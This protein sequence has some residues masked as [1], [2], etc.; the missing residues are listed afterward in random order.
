MGS[1]QGLLVACS[2]P[3]ASARSS[4]PHDDRGRGEPYA[5]GTW[6]L[7]GWGSAV[8]LW[9]LYDGGVD[10]AHPHE[11]HH[12]GT[13]IGA[14]TS[15]LPLVRLCHT[16]LNHNVS[17]PALFEIVSLSHVDSTKVRPIQTWSCI[18][19]YGTGTRCHH[20]LPDTKQVLPHG[21]PPRLLL[22]PTV[23]VS[24]CHPL[25]SLARHLPDGSAHARWL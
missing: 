13:H 6:W 25:F 10:W 12:L 22:S 23:P 5:P 9:P 14:R 15:P 4:T 1:R 20:I 16:S 11:G 7:V 19:C 8:L 17:M 2:L 18:C 3:G 24:H 21:L